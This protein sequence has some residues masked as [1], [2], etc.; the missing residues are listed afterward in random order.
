MSRTEF[1]WLK[2][3]AIFKQQTNVNKQDESDNFYELSGNSCKP[4]MYF[5]E[6]LEHIA[7]ILWNT[8]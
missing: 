4:Q 1:L 3:S 2:K 5:V 7:F 8:S 6:I